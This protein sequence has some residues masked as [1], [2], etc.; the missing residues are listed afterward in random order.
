MSINLHPTMVA[1]WRCLCFWPVRNDDIQWIFHSSTRGSEKIL[2]RLG[3][4][5][6]VSASMM[7]NPCI[8]TNKFIAINERVAYFWGTSIYAVAFLLKCR[9]S[10]RLSAFRR[11]SKPGICSVLLAKVEVPVC[12]IIN[13]HLP[14]GWKRAHPSLNILNLR[15]VMSELVDTN[16][17]TITPCRV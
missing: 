6:A 7:S 11:A 9:Q 1:W 16:R 12:C 5:Q 14:I 4:V 15:G 13:H 8:W 10:Q 2:G 17:S 3:R